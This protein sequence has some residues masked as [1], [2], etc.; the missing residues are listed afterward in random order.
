MPPI[1]VGSVVMAKDRCITYNNSQMRGRKESNNINYT[2]VSLNK[3]NDK[4]IH[5]RL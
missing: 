3:N 4:A 1:S 5:S 2:H